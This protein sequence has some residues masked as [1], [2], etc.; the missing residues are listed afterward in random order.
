MFF[1]D[2]SQKP[3]LCDK[4]VDQAQWDNI[5]ALKFFPRANSLLILGLESNVG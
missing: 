5:F 2:M 4:L 1:V 3:W